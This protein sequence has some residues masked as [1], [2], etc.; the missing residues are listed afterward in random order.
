MPDA[1]CLGLTT[2]GGT[3]TAGALSV[4]G[5][6]FPD[7]ESRQTEYGPP[8]ADHRPPTADRRPPTAD[9]RPPTADRRPPTA[10]RRPPT[11][12]RSRSPPGAHHPA[13]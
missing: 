9:R 12:A 6:D 4:F 3:Q 5:N 7:P 1:A 8:T 10:D 11:A 13:E 2:V